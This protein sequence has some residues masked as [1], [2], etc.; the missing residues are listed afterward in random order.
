MKFKRIVSV[1]VFTL[2]TSLSFVFSQEILGK[3][4]TSWSSVLPGEV[5]SEPAV[6]SY[7]FCV[8]TDGRTISAYSND[9]LLLWEKST[10]SSKNVSITGL[11][12]DFII[13]WDKRNET[14]KLFNPSGTVLWEKNLDF[15]LIN[16]PLPGRDGRFFISGKD[17]VQCYGING[18]CKWSVETN[19]QRNLGI[20]ELPD[21]SIVVFLKEVEGKTKA[22]RISPFGKILEDI[23]LAGIVKSSY[24]INDG[25][26]LTFTDGSSGLFSIIDGL[27]KNKWVLGVKP[28]NSLLVCNSSNFLFLELFKDH[29]IVD[30]IDSKDGTIVQQFTINNIN[31]LNLKIA[32]L[33]N[34]GLFIADSDNCYVYSLKGLKN[35]SAQ[36]LED[37]SSTRWNYVIYTNDNHIVFCLE[38]WSLNSYLTV[39]TRVRQKSALKNSYREYYSIDTTPYSYYFTD[40]ISRNIV[41]EERF[42]ILKNGYYGEDEIEYASDIFS[43]CTAYLHSTGKMHT[44]KTVSIF[45]QDAYGTES[46]FKQLALFC[47]NDSAFYLSKLIASTNNRAYLNVLFSSVAQCGYDPD[48]KILK[49]LELAIKKIDRKENS[50]LKSACDAVFSICNFMGIPAYNRKGKEIL[51]NLFM[52]QYDSVI[53]EYARDT[54]MKI[55]EIENT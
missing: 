31:G 20:Q 1:V 12:G 14:I 55:I 34:E 39:Q 22:L 44:T 33:T 6:T 15:E 2:F 28:E 42:T 26:F 41:N 40:Q 10:G 54:M 49:E 17:V 13:L 38:N 3:F 18:I 23:T 5:V 24:T 32:K 47:T 37:K 25:V 53:R 21:G 7:G 9:G 52:P 29:V 16:N 4:N 46:C 48:G 50:T 43:M 35:W 19:E 30:R 11:P 27:S 36:M 45:D 8:V 51:K